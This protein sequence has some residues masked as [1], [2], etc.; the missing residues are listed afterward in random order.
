MLN[1]NH[2]QY[3][4]NRHGG[5]PP[6][7]N[8]EKFKLLIALTFMARTCR[9]NAVLLLLAAGIAMGQTPDAH[10]IVRR[11]VDVD[12]K[13]WVRI[14]DYGYTE[15]VKKIDLDKDGDPKKTDIKAFDV[16]F[17]D[18]SP[19]KRLIS[20][21]D[22]PLSPE[23]EASEKAKREA[24]DEERRNET[25]EQRRKRIEEYIEKR[26]KNRAAIQ[27]VP[28]AF[29]FRLIGEEEVNGRPAWVIEATPRHGYHPIN[30]R[31]KLFTQLEGKLWIDKAS[32]QWARVQAKL[33]DGV[34]F[35]WILV[36]M[37]KGGRV[38][39]ENVPLG[40]GLWAPK[41]LWYTVSLRV[42]LVKNYRVEEETRYSDYRAPEVAGGP[43]G[44]SSAEP[45]G[46]AASAR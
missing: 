5:C 30:W 34:S 33:V 16:E 43:E 19:Y 41:R 2:I 17:L 10:E 44:L 35:G 46:Q 7:S 21:F 12:Q 29:N 24:V 42:G 6:Q 31:A 36:R 27:E 26:D 39:V 23:E 25:P 22:E 4:V 11:S 45:A 20:R 40:D 14:R 18:G 9:R 37:H 28:N 1:G 15:W 32:Y 8:D 13:N 38:E 3:G